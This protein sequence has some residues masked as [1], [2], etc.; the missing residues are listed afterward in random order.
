MRMSRIH[1][2]LCLKLS[3]ICEVKINNNLFSVL[4]SKAFSA[5]D[6]KNQWIGE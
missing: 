5:K 6:N 2:S 1:S 4:T 3:K